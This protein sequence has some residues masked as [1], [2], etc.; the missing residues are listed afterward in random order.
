MAT[1]A[2]VN[3]TTSRSPPLLLIIKELFWLSVEFEF[4]L[5]A[6]HLPG[7]FNLYSDKLS[8]L[9]DVYDANYAMY[10]L[11]GGKMSIVSCNDHMSYSAYVALQIAWQV[12]LMS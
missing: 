10:L 4:R 3:N 9:F 11:T 8:R 7:K 1:V 5:S 6:I 12:A 2:A